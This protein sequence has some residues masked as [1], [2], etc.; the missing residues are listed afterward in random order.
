MRIV[1]VIKTPQG[2]GHKISECIERAKAYKENLGY[3][4]STR[5]RFRQGRA[6]GRR[7]APRAVESAGMG[8][9]LDS[10]VL[11]AAERSAFYPGCIRLTNPS[12]SRRVT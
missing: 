8:L 3:P 2:P 6:S 4:P 5:S 11:I 9:V 12:P 1:D 10:G 7:C